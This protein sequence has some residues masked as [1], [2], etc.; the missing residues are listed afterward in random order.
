M[1]RIKWGSAHGRQLHRH[2]QHPLPRRVKLR[3]HRL[4]LHRRQ[5]RGSSNLHQRGSVSG[6]HHAARHAHGTRAS[7]R[8]PIGS[9]SLL[10]E[11]GVIL[12]R[13][14]SLVRCSLHR[15]RVVTDDVFVFMMF[16]FFGVGALSRAR[17]ASRDSFGFL[18]SV[19]G[20][21][22]REKRLYYPRARVK[23]RRTHSSK[24]CARA[25]VT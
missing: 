6:R 15:V 4:E 1:R 12:V 11:L 10:D 7:Q 23:G 14:Q 13:V 19:D 3:R 21:L 25:C 2:V 17:R 16:L 5:H 24:V 20:F 8:P 22:L 18:F 9:G